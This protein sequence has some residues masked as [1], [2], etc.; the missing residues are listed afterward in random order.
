LR[1]TGDFDAWW[2][3]RIHVDQPGQDGVITATPSSKDGL[4]AFAYNL[5]VDDLS[6]GS[7]RLVWDGPAINPKH[8]ETDAAVIAVV[9]KLGI[10]ATVNNIAAEAKKSKADVIA[11]LKRQVDYGRLRT[12]T[13]F[14]AGGQSA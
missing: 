14:T 6:D 3:N 11:S 12:E 1:G 8:A 4:A 5:H 10:Q 9:K 13:A 2:R 7:A